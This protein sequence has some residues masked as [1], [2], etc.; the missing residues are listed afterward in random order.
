MNAQKGGNPITI[1]EVVLSAK[2]FLEKDNE[3]RRDYVLILHNGTR[4]DQLMDALK[5][6][7]LPY[8]LTEANHYLGTS[9][10]TRAP[11]YIIDVTK[12]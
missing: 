6:A 1:D 5:S 9:S 11:Y 10:E 12:I 3:Q 4:P 2:T 7:K 8:F